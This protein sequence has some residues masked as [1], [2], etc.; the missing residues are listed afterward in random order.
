[1]T[2]YAFSQECGFQLSR[3]FISS[4]KRSAIFEVNEVRSPLP[5][6]SLLHDQHMFAKVLLERRLGR[7][8]KRIRGSSGASDGSNQMPIVF[9]WSGN[10]FL[11]CFLLVLPQSRCT[12]QQDCFSLCRKLLKQDAK[13][14]SFQSA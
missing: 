12:N 1:M 3:L 2:K 9:V 7:S 11:C 8:F 5:W 6:L 4:R 13:Q 10:C 14:S